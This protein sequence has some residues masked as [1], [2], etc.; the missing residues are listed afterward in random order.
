MQDVPVGSNF[1]WPKPLLALAVMKPLCPVVLSYNV[2]LQAT[3]RVMQSDDES[4][5]GVHEQVSR[6]I[7]SYEY[8]MVASTGLGGELGCGLPDFGDEGKVDSLNTYQALTSCVL[9]LT[10]NGVLQR[11]SML[12]AAHHLLDHSYRHRAT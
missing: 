8:Y 1:T 9:E 11:L 5:A 3:S 2:G 6:G 12:R 10:G 7:G 4:I